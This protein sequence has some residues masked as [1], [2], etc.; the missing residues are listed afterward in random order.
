M[1]FLQDAWTRFKEAISHLF[2][3]ADLTYIAPFAVCI[4]AAH[5]W[6]W[7]TCMFIES[8]TEHWYEERHPEVALT[9]AVCDSWEANK[10][11]CIHLVELSTL[12]SARGQHHFWIMRFYH[13]RNSGLLIT[14]YWSST[15]AAC[16]LVAIMKSGWDNADPRIR[17]MFL[18]TTS[19]AAFFGGFP[20]LIS[21]QQNIDENQAAY[22]GYDNVAMSLRSYLL[23]ETHEDPVKRVLEADE[24]LRKLNAIHLHFDA[25]QV[26]LGKTRFLEAQPKD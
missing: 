21:A 1:I 9:T 16:F 15:V 3:W 7:S 10:P 17:V 13:V 20:S 26:D 12:A 6:F 4:L 5:V 2:T 11:A 18:A 24:E 23:V 25:T 22:V 14:A 19:A 8:K